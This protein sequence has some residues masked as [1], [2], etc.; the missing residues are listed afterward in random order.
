MGRW[1]ELKGLSGSAA[2]ATTA[3]QFDETSTPSL[4][5]DLVVVALMCRSIFDHLRLPQE[6]EH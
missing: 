4:L 3:K 5:P 6:S 2:H 1:V